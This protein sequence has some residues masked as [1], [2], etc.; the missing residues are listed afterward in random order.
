VYRPE[1]LHDVDQ[2]H[3]K[4]G[5]KTC[6]VSAL[7]DDLQTMKTYRLNAAR[8]QGMTPES[9][10]TAWADG[11]HN[12]WAVL[13]VVAPQCQTLECML[14]WLHIGKKLQNVKNALG[15][16]FATSLDSVKGTLWHGKAREALTKLALLRDKST[17]EAKRSKITGLHDYIQRNHAYIV[18]YAERDNA[19]TPYTSQGAESH[20]DT[21]IN[22]RH[23]RTRKMQWTR[24]GAHHGLQIRAMIAS[25]EWESKWHNAVLSTLTA[26]A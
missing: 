3:R 9:Q 19:K 15:E 25:E 11:A 17:E 16:A 12:G 24:E 23:T 18:N 13:S 22:A 8:K 6:V 7:D 10:G 1:S 20:V 14:A 4:I 2:H 26:A 21:I 5:E